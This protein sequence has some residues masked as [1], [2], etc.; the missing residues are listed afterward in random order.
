[1]D[2]DDIGVVHFS[3]EVKMW[4]RILAATSLE[5]GD[6]RREVSH[7][8]DATNGEGG[9]TGDVAF[10]ERL[11][12]YQRGHDLWIAKNAASEDYLFHGCRREG[13]KIFV[14]NKDITGAL[15]LMVQKVLGVAVRATRVWNE[16]YEKLAWPTLLEE[17]TKPR[18]PEGCFD[19]GTCVE[20]SW[21]SHETVRWLPAQVLGVHGSN[22][23]YAV[24]FERGGEW[25][26][27]E[28]NVHPERVRLPTAC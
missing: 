4:H 14:G 8:L 3:G 26:D 28:R 1:M 17:L 23:H 21:C 19:V 22:K 13:H 12:S 27:T 18:V 5:S 25:G 6:R 16:C 15:D 11:M 7:A 24:R 20:V 2:L 10:A 9:E